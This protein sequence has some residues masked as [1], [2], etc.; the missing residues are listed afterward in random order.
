MEWNRRRGGSGDENWRMGSQ[1]QL[2]RRGAGAASGERC[3]TLLLHCQNARELRVEV[4][5]P[6][7]HEW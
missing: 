1:V 7:T 2:V 5:R 3:A 4:R 6:L